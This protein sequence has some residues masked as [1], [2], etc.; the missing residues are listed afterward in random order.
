MS[1]M[2]YVFISRFHRQGHRTS[3]PEPDRPTDLCPYQHCP[4]Q[5]AKEF[6]IFLFVPGETVTANSLLTSYAGQR[7]LV[8]Y[9]P[10]DGVSF[11]QWRPCSKITTAQEVNHSDYSA[12]TG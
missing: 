2:R 7:S 3:S 5:S 4:K 12:V 11:E 6:I 10:R 1:L 9:I 8:A